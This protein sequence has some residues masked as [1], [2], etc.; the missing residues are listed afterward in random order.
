MDSCNGVKRQI[1]NVKGSFLVLVTGFQ[2]LG[3]AVG[4]AVAASLVNNGDYSLVNEVAA[5][6]CAASILMFLYII[7]RTRHMESPMAT[8]EG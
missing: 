7:Y 3:A 8:S 2:G 5:L 6:S 4:P 1:L